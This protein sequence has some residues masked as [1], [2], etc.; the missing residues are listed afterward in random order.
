[1]ESPER[2]ASG[3]APVITRADVEHVAQL[4][5]LGL[6]DEE[7]EALTRDLGAILEHADQVRS[8]STEGVPPTSHP[9]PLRNVLRAD[10]ARPGID[11][12]EVLSQAPER[13]GD[14]F[15]VPRILGEEP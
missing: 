13:E 9:V 7:I 5:R 6:T 2:A 12:E 10:V 1:V 8:L 4:A 15:R 3:R 11:R 14:R